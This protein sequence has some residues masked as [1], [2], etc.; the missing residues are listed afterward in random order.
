MI[1]PSSLVF[2]LR[3]KY[4][5]DGWGR[6]RSLPPR[7][8]CR[9]INNITHSSLAVFSNPALMLR[10]SRGN[11][12]LSPSDY[13]INASTLACSLNPPKKDRWRMRTPRLSL[14]DWTQPSGTTRHLYLLKRKQNS[15]RNVSFRSFSPT[16]ISTVSHNYSKAIDN[17]ALEVW[18]IME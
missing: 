17:W 5:W 1:T 4:N 13:L 15:L 11:T 10:N 2:P 18:E 16:K 8:S 9:S 12:Q 7:G 3:Y 14:R 6:R